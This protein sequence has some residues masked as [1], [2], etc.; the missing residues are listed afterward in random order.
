MTASSTLG[1][2]TTAGRGRRGTVPPVPWLPLLAFLVVAAAVW[3]VVWWSAG[4]L[5]RHP[6]YYP[7]PVP[8][9]GGPLFEGWA[10]WDGF[11]Y[12]TIAEEGYVYY[13]GVQ[14]SVAFFPGYPLVMRAVSVAV[15][16]LFVAGSLTT[17]VAGLLAIRWLWAWLTARMSV[18]AAGV[19]LGVVLLYPFSWYLFGAVYA[20]ALFLA[21][22]IG[23]FVA[24]DRDRIWTA[25]LL[26]FVASASRPTGVA[27]AVGL[28]LVTLEKRNAARRVVAGAVDATAAAVR[29]EPVATGAVEGVPGRSHGAIDHA[30]ASAVAPASSGVAGRA[31]RAARALGERFDPRGFGREDAPL[32]LAF[33]GLV[34]YMAYLWVRFGHPLLFS[35]IQGVKG[36]DQ[37]AGWT[38]WLKL[39]VLHKLTTDPF[40]DAGVMMVVQAA[41]TAVALALVPR[42]ARRFGWGYAAY[43]LAVVAIPVLGSKDFVGLGRYL[44]PAFPCFAV[45]GEGLARRPAGVRVGAFRMLGTGLLAMA[46]F[47]ARGYYLS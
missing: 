36:W 25:G 3:L 11:W 10:R 29:P 26:G 28:V 45:V 14:S 31:R 23:A 32:L 41:L 17:F 18:R 2:P 1:R 22:A 13:P 47:F 38:T 5:P 44:L 21:A 37:P 24:V 33:G 4:H 16:N 46:S 15:P 34:A 27:V 43:V 42:V 6:Q 9:G 35:E 39:P 19:T 30:D 12:R 8:G 7:S 20:D 40:S